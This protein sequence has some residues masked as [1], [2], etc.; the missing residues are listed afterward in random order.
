MWSARTLSAPPS[1]P[2]CP[3]SLALFLQALGDRV[4]PHLTIIAAGL[5]QASPASRA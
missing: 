3:P 1:Q 5:P 4:R 2:S